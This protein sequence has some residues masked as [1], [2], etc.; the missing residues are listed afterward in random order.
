MAFGLFDKPEV[1]SAVRAAASAAVRP[2]EDVGSV[3]V[4]VHK[5]TARF[6]NRTTRVYI[7]LYVEIT[8]L[9]LARLILVSRKKKT[10]RGRIF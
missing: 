7:I 9:G 6:G 8:I 5:F 10:N 4:I 2:C 1:A 3:G